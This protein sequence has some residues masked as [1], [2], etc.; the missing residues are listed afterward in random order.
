[1]RKLVAHN[2]PTI[3]YKL[4]VALSLKV[5]VCPIAM[6]AKI[7]R[8]LTLRAKFNALVIFTSY[9]NIRFRVLFSGIAYRF[10]QA[11]FPCMQN[12]FGMRYPFKISDVVVCLVAVYVV[13]LFFVVWVWNKCLRY[14]SVYKSFV[15]LMVNT[16][17]Y[18]FITL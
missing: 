2:N 13:D 7:K 12:V 18:K 10:A 8:T 17:L 11:I 4:I 14:K 9:H 1:M 6:L 5:L 3:I 15:W 16:Q